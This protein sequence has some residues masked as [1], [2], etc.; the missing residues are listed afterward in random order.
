MAVS[1]RGEIAGK[2]VIGLVALVLLGAVSIAPIPPAQA[3]ATGGDI[4]NVNP[5]GPPGA[6]PSSPPG[7]DQFDNHTQ[8]Q[9]SG[10][11]TSP[12]GLEK[13][14]F[15]ILPAQQAEQFQSLASTPDGAVRIRGCMDWCS[16][17]TRLCLVLQADPAK[18]MP[19][20]RTTG[21]DCAAVLAAARAAASSI[22]GGNT[23]PDAIINLTKVLQQCPPAYKRPID[24][25]DM[26][27]DAQSKIR[28][29][30]DYSRRRA[31]QALDCYEQKPQ[32]PPQPTESG[33]PSCSGADCGCLIVGSLAL[34][35][36]GVILAQAAPQQTASRPSP[37][38]LAPGT[39]DTYTRGY[40]NELLN[41]LRRVRVSNDGTKTWLQTNVGLY[42]MIKQSDDEKGTLYLVSDC[43]KVRLRIHL[44]P[45][46]TVRTV[47]D[48]NYGG[49]DVYYFVHGKPL[50]SETWV[51][52]SSP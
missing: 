32:P 33:G 9:E 36:A 27:V 43:Y 49:Y 22:E 31:Q 52:A 25:F 46:Y 1:S 16:A 44:N 47:K 20:P 13:W 18:P 10:W 39:Y 42:P 34:P 35:K 28:T 19:K 45:P 7:G 23:R 38:A 15:L 8:C 4:F 11:F 26:M 30:A 40:N 29:A 5:G 48:T 17:T 2:L 21:T 37:N 3:Q 41:N 50:K 6:P 14:R 12:D 24:C 51:P